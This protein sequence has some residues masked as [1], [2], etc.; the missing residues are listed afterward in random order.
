MGRK[1]PA[2]KH[3]GV[4]DP[5]LQHARRMQGLKNKINAPPKDPDDQPVPHSL[6]RLFAFQN[7]DKETRI[8][9][10]KKIQK[11]KLKDEYSGSGKD[12]NPI[13]QLKKLP[14]ESGRGFSL[15][16]NSAIRALHDPINQDDYP[17]DLEEDDSKGERMM[18]LRER[19]QRKHRKKNAKTDDE[20]PKLTRGQK[21]SLKKKTK[22][23]KA[24]EEEAIKE[25]TYDKV[26]FGE[27][28]HAPPT[29]TVRPKMRGQNLMQDGAPRPGRKDLLLTSM[30]SGKTSKK[31]ANINAAD[32]A[33]RERARLDVVAAY[34]ELK[35]QK[36]EESKNKMK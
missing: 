21:L 25:V 33:R 20:E 34:R 29:F 24:K 22:L 12:K 14:G 4:K 18:A 17:Q 23:L 15:R 10:V 6:T 19:R 8:K 26:E 32:L 9:D 28:T 5:L 31:D 36:R 3:R 30:L 1:I 7:K 2:K 16:I 11:R 13:T 27:V 35:K